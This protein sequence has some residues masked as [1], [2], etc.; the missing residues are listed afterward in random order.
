MPKE[1][2]NQLILSKQVLS[3]RYANEI[4]SKGNERSSYRNLGIPMFSINFGIRKTTISINP[5]IRPIGL[6]TMDIIENGS[7]ICNKTR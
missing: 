1:I 2:S 4:N 6:F 7:L 3:H 5:I